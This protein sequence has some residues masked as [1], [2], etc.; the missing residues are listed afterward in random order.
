MRKATIFTFAAGLFMMCGAGCSAGVD[1]GEAGTTDEAAVDTTKQE[2]TGWLGPISDEAAYN[3]RTFAQANVGA[4]NGFCSGSYCDNNYIYGSPLPA[5]VYTGT[6]HPTGL[7]ISEEAPNNASFCVDSA[8]YLSGVVTGLAAS[9]G[10]SDNIE[11]VCAPLSF[12]SGHGWNTCKWTNWFSEESGGYATGW[13]AG[14]YAT[15]LNCSGS[16]CDNMRYYI[17]NFN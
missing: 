7:F 11:L 3:Y 4:T 13:P 6:E 2:L 5:G 8:G 15:G 14:Y 10:N 1:A 17:C 16:R 12:G 9:G